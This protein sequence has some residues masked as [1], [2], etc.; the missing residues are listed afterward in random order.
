M[1]CSILFDTDCLVQSTLDHPLFLVIHSCHLIMQFNICI[2]KGPPLSQWG[3]LDHSVFCVRVTYCNHYV[4]QKPSLT[5]RPT[6]ELPSIIRS[7]MS[8]NTIYLINP[9][10]S[11]IKFYFRYIIIW[12]RHGWYTSLNWFPRFSRGVMVF[13]IFRILLLSRRTLQCISVHQR[14][15]RFI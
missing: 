4:D 6:G 3:T 13:L 11:Q 14:S 2:L 15:F 7:L 10:L 1:V 12:T 5:S 8:L 9:D